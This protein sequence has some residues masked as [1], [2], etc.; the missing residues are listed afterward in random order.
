MGQLSWL[1]FAPSVFAYSQ[2]SSP[3]IPRRVTNI[4]IRTALVGVDGVWLVFLEQVQCHGVAFPRIEA[5]QR[6]IKAARC[7]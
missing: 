3:H 2:K 7:G 1:P 5:V 6:K 4:Q